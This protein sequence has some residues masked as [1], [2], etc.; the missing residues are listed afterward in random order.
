[1]A[2]TVV[3]R[4]NA[5]VIIGPQRPTVII[6]ERINPTGK[7][8]LKQA[9]CDAD[10]K[11][12]AA[13]AREQVAAGAQVID[14][15][16]MVAGTS[17]VETLPRAV[18]AVQKAVE[19]PLCLDC[20]R[21][22]ALQAALRVCDGKV[23]V[24]SVNGDQEKLEAVL[25]LVRQHKAGVIGLTMDKASGI[26]KLASERLR[27]ATR[28]LEGVRAEGIPESDLIIDCLTLAVSVEQAMGQVALDTM[29][30]VS[31]DLGLNVNMGVSNVSFGLPER[32]LFNA[33]FIAMAAAAG[34]TCAIVNPHSKPVLEAILASDVLLGRDARA[35]L[36][37]VLPHAEESSRLTM[38]SAAT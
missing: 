4:N 17:E 5:E 19:V 24:N 13:L 36:S 14:I 29:R 38:A 31:R 8:W 15:N 2:E 33:A 21:A 37:E 1:M 30:A 3:T 35:Q 18:E 26:P 27:I 23:I 11:Q 16:V 32:G 25:P 12:V 7:E 28:I 10:Y 9:I 34:M 22:E 20:S 6:G